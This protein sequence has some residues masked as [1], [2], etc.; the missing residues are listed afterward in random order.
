MSDTSWNKEQL[1]SSE[2]HDWAT[3]QALFTRVDFEF[4]FVLDAAASPHNTKCRDHLSVKDDALS[5]D[6]TAIA[7]DISDTGAVWLNPP[8]GRDIGKW[9]QKAYEESCKGLVVVVLTFCRSDTKWWMKAS[10]VRLIKGRVRFEGAPSSAP[11]PSCLLIFDESKR[12][13]KFTV[14][15]DLPRR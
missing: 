8:Y 15:D 9:I 7:G 4:G 1:F 10:E 14:I 12:L 11:A 13:P 3:P 5:C 6:W 2:K